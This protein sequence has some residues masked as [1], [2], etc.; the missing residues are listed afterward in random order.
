MAGPHGFDLWN[1]LI[2]TIASSLG[3]VLSLA[4]NAAFKGTFELIPLGMKTKVLN[5]WIYVVV[6][7]TVQSSSCCY[8]Q[9]TQPNKHA[10]PKNLYLVPASIKNKIK[11]INTVE[12]K[13][14]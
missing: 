6:V 1:N 3:F 12:Q 9:Y 13:E 14:R 4:L 2:D 10:D 11:T 8:G 5:D 7:G